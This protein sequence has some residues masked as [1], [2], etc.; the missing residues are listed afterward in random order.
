VTWGEDQARTL[1]RLPEY[2][3]CLLGRGHHHDAIIHT[4]E[5]LADVLHHVALAGFDFDGNALGLS[6]RQ[7]VSGPA[8]RP[9]GFELDIV[10]CLS[11]L[12]HIVTFPIFVRE[13]L[14]PR[15]LRPGRRF[16]E[17]RREAQ[18][19]AAP[20]PNRDP[21]LVEE[22]SRRLLRRVPASALSPGRW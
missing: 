13:G 10:V 11:E 20:A 3:P 21:L 9:W 7:D 15:A 14:A 19:C 8:G 2:L 1:E 18:E 16:R 6:R 12:V 4:Q 22:A 17:Q 5:V